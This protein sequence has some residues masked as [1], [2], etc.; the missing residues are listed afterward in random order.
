MSLSFDSTFGNKQVSVNCPICKSQ[1][2]ITLNQVGS[3]IFCP[4]C[5][6]SIDLQA[7]NNFN[8]SKK[9]IDKSFKDLNKTLKSFGK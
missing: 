4:Y 5:K 1:M 9:S 6:K 8:S 7:G 2:K 3:T